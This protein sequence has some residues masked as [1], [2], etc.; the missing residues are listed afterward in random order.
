MR[1]PLSLSLCLC[2][3]LQGHIYS[4]GC[5]LCAALEFVI[6]PELRAELGAETK[7]LLEQMQQENPEDR[8][9]PQDILSLGE[10]RLTSSS[11]LTICR[12]LSSIGRRV[13][14]IE[15]VAT[16]QDRWE[17]SWE[18]HWRQVKACQLFSEQSSVDG[19]SGV[20][21]NHIGEWVA[22]GSCA[23]NEP[24]DDVNVDDDDLPLPQC[25]CPRP[26]ASPWRPAEKDTC[27]NGLSGREAYGV[28][29]DMEAFQGPGD[30][31]RSQNSSPVHCRAPARRKQPWAVLNRSWSV[32]DSH[33][34]P[35]ML[36]PPP[37]PDIS[38][39]VDDLTEIGEEEEEPR[40]AGPLAWNRALRR[41]SASAPPPEETCDAEVS[42]ASAHM[43]SDT[44]EAAGSADWSEQE[45]VDDDDQTSPSSS[46]AETVRNN[47]MYSPNNHM[48]K[49]MLCLNEESQDE[50]ISLRE[51]LTRC[52]RPLSVK[53]LWALCY[54][55]LA[56]LQT[57]IDFPAYLCLDTMYVGCEGEILF[58]KPKNTG[59]CDAF[60]LAPEYLEHGI[61]TEKAC[62]Y[63]VAAI[64]WATAKFSL[65][66]HQKLA[67]PRK[68]KRLLLEMAKRTPIERPTIVMAKKSCRDY[69]S[70]QGTTAEAVWTLLI[71]RVHKSPSGRPGGTHSGLDGTSSEADPKAAF[72]PIASEGRLA[73]VSGPV[74][75]SYPISMATHLPEA[76][77]SPATHFIP[78][79]LARNEATDQE[80]P[81]P[82][83]GT[84]TSTNRVAMTS[85]GP[86]PGIPSVTEIVTETPSHASGSPLPHT[87]TNQEEAD[88]GVA[89]QVVGGAMLNDPSSS[90]SSSQTLV[91]STPPL[92]HPASSSPPANQDTR[93]TQV[94][95]PP[96]SFLPVFNNFL[97]QQDPQ[98]GKITLLP[99]QIA[100]AVQ[101]LPGQGLSSL[102]LALGAI[103]G[104]ISDQHILDTSSGSLNT[105]TGCT[106]ATRTHCQA[107]CSSACVSVTSV[108]TPC[109]QT[110]TPGHHEPPPSHSTPHP[111]HPAVQRV[112]ALLKE[113]FA[114]DGYLEDGIQELA[115]GEYIF[116]LRYLQFGTF[117]Q[118]IT[119]KFHDLYWEK[120]LLAML[121]CAV[122]YDL[123]SAASNEQQP[124]KPSKRAAPS[125]L[126]AGRRDPR[127]QAEC[128]HPDRPANRHLAHSLSTPANPP[129]NKNT[130]RT[131]EPN[132]AESRRDNKRYDNNKTTAPHLQEQQQ[133]VTSEESE[134]YGGT[135]EVRGVAGSLWGLM[136]GA[137]DPAEEAPDESPSEAEPLSL[138][139]GWEEPEGPGETE[140]VGQLGQLGSG[141]SD[142]GRLH[143]D[144][145]VDMEDADS[146]GSNSL[147]APGYTRG[148]QG[149]VSHRP[150]WALA[151][152]GGGCFSQEVMQYAENLGRHTNGSTS[153]EE[154]AQELHQQL[155]I[156]TRNMRKTRNFH[157][158]LLKQD[159]KSKGSE[160]KVMLSKLKIQ[161]EELKAK[162]EFLDTV[163]KYLE[164]LRLDLQGVDVALL[165]SLALA[166]SGGLEPQV[167]DD[168]ALLTLLPE[169][170]RGKAGLAGSGSSLLVSG[171]PLGLMAY[172]YARDAHIEGYIQQFLYTYRYFCKPEYLLQFLM[173]TFRRVAGEA[174]DDPSSDSA[175]VYNRT[176]DLLHCWVEDCR[177]VDFTSG[178]QLQH[179]LSTFLSSEV[180]PL[181]SRAESLLAVLQ[182][183]PGRRWNQGESAPCRSPE[184]A[185][186]V[187][188]ALHALSSRRSSVDDG[189]KK[190]F[191][192]R[193]SR[194]VEPQPKEPVYSIAAALP[195]PCYS[196]LLKQMGP[197]PPGPLGPLA[198]WPP[199]P[200]GPL[201]PSPP[202]PLRP[203][204]RLPFSEQQHSA[205]HTAQQLTLLEQEMFHCCHPVHFLNSRA[206]GVRDKS[207]GVTRCLSSEALPVEGATHVPS[208][209]SPQESPLL[210]L[211]RYADSVT[212]WVSAE[213]V[214]CDSVKAQASLLAKFLSVAKCC[215]ESRNF[216]TAMQILAGLEHVIIRQLPAWKHLSVKVCE[217]VE[218]LRAVQVS[219][220]HASLIA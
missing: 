147:G 88:E 83:T 152:H 179:T 185:L 27:E 100:T 34:P 217:I 61:V 33:D 205:L 212:N 164:V 169:A 4:L 2:F 194:V 154:K 12:K 24:R 92:Y 76:F 14:S 11:S 58:L 121:Y 55:C 101:S 22:S 41:G 190:G 126:S 165:P 56:T 133:E 137:G 112:T 46:S 173:D 189:G 30:S 48:T 203:E 188:E 170:R 125:P 213:I 159:R 150:G 196:S 95:A 60:Y 97:L 187:G 163:R 115:M 43:P 28:I 25:H 176:L 104:Q 53:E 116:S 72:K 201:A 15:S 82:H 109:A 6:E 20:V 210:Q 78:I 197:S 161:F 18:S 216:A 200:L 50:W 35:P 124:S 111:A 219:S 47:H 172:L 87:A 31:S 23:A 146:L 158:K 57:Y 5:T 85:D 98:T 151:L 51:L 93:T 127:A 42:H 103:Q 75:H 148:P 64:L 141:D 106:D 26:S 220:S 202:C 119:E 77:T 108:P 120:D 102:P 218:E 174:R 129:L 167:Q 143:R 19:C 99:V 105:F 149:P 68:L 71:N 135:V 65:S 166:V 74:P 215:Y 182:G 79:V 118:V 44:S 13:L 80:L 107:N 59:S 183:E 90:S 138:S 94:E 139:E 62:V 29:E 198:P 180:A 3:V 52:S 175:K 206:L 7:R 84:E 140:V 168:P 73:P 156:E 207:A 37:Y 134:G 49:S 54:T 204:D 10:L 208:E 69:L 114:Y 130:V 113:Q 186:E 39:H 38:S 96:S 131:T 16:L 142:S 63:G 45:V 81:T 9:R 157:H 209:A 162:V 70:R 178:T 171:T 181:D 199:G 36:S 66:P 195:R 193:L 155:I 110:S 132:T 40:L 191:Q 8:P 145:S 177:W 123:L 86:H 211:L 192:W 21:G 122:N 184:C 117:C 214:I 91:N 160:A 89:S 144:S 153:L 1:A 67:M 32:P 128:S 17:T 136:E